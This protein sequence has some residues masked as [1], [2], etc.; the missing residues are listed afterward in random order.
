MY[1]PRRASPTVV[2]NIHQRTNTVLIVDYFF[3]PVAG[4]GVARTLGYVN[5]LS[6]FGW[7]PI[8]LTA[9]SGDHHYFDISLMERVPSTVDVQRT[10]SLEPVRFAKRLLIMSNSRGRTGLDGV[11]TGSG[12]PS[13][14]GSRWVSDVERWLLFPDRYIGWL[15]F[16]VA[17]AVT[18]CRRKSIDVIYSTSTAVTSHLIA[19]FLKR[20]LAKPWVADFQDPLSQ[21]PLLNFASLLHKKALEKIEQLILRNA[22][23][24]V[25]TTEEHQ[26]MIQEK[27]S[28]RS[29]KFAVIPMGFDSAA[30]EGVRAIRR[31]KFTLTHFGGF[32]GS[33]SPEF[34]LE[35]LSECMST[36]SSLADDVEVLFFG[37]FDAATLALTER[38]LARHGLREKVCLKGI[39]PYKVGLE[40]LASSA[41]LLLVADKGGWGRNM[42]SA[43][44]PEYLAAGRPIL[45]LA[46]EGAIA[47]VVRKARAGLIVEPDDVRGIQ[48]AILELYQ[49]WREGRLTS[50]VDHDVVRKFAWEELTAEF[51]AVL[52]SAVARRITPGYIV[53]S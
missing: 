30:F 31:P 44:L 33:R 10:L 50:S 46:P 37:S 51:V 38:L 28:T 36:R 43:K 42:S 14:R 40:Y 35:A 41:V 24:V 4:P 8:V 15:P 6:K 3:P 29:D 32:Y 16:A 19:Y 39:V 53:G 47:R 12:R 23:R 48:E 20:F 1:K 2:P 52:T 11:A 18:L 21:N 22:D 49:L 45:A 5:N 7:I 17:R 25:V 26:R 34:F 9:Q 27:F 13:W